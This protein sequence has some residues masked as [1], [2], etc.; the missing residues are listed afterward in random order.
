MVDILG[1]L[2]LGYLEIGFF[3][4]LVWQLGGVGG[5]HR[6]G[7][8]VNIA[9]WPLLWVVMLSE[10]WPWLDRMLSRCLGLGKKGG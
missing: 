9:L 2:L 1:L 10:Q 6:K 5:F 4:W 8:F 3:H 7:F